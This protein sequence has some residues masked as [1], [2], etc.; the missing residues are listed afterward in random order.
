MPATIHDYTATES[1][2]LQTGVLGFKRL[3][4]ATRHVAAD[5]TTPT[6]W[7]DVTGSELVTNGGFDSDTGWTK[8]TGWTITSGYASSDGS[9][10]GDA[11]M[12]Q[13]LGLTPSAIYQTVFTVANRSAGNV[14]V[15]VGD[16]EGTDRASNA[17]FTEYVTCGAGTDL[18]LRA[19]A[20]F[21]GDVD[22]VSVKLVSLGA[23][24]VTNGAMAADSD[25]T[26]GVGWTIA[27]GTATSDGSQAADADLTQTFALTPGEIYQVTFTVSGYAAG[28][29]CAVVGDTEGTDRGGDGTFVEYITAGAGADFDIRA[30]AD[31]VGSIDNVVVKLVTLGANLATN[32]T[33]ATSTGWTLG[34]GWTITTGYATSDGSQVAVSDLEQTATLTDSGPYRVIFS[35]TSRSAGNV[36]PLIGG[37]VGTNRATVATFTETVVASTVD[38]IAIRA[39]ADF[40]GRVDVVSVQAAVSYTAG[41]YVTHN[42][43]DYVCILTHNV[44]APVDEPGVGTSWDTYWKLLVLYPT[45]REFVAA[46]A[47]G[48]ALV[49][50]GSCVAVSG[51]IP[52]ADDTIR[53]D[54]MLWGRFTTVDIKTGYC[55]AYYL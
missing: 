54:D 49:F 13:A 27:A 7:D 28:N 17:T 2:G 35:V 14:T 4:A 34:T 31:F 50:G 15:V 44:N 19:D 53:Q 9:Q 5:T 16:Q 51:D 11:D 45:L 36:R 12:T 3:A 43:A 10:S 47:V 23:D 32:S 55:Y 40:V 25:W 24:L 30:D 48:S 42:S 8:G 1:L 21:V 41:D 29:V 33:F 46:K 22:T 20:N 52:A 6:A 38:K 26:K 39:D 18:D 37:T